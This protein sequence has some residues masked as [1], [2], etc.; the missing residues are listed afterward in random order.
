MKIAQ[1]APLWFSLPPKKFGGTELIAYNLSEKLIKRDHQ[2]TVFASGDS[3]VSGKL[4]SAWPKHLIKEKINGKVIPWNNAHFPLLNIYEAFSRANEFDI[5]HIHEN[6]KIL[7]SFFID[8]IK[9]PV[10]T[11]LHDPFPNS[12]SKD[13]LAVYN[14]FK[15]HNYI[16]ISNTH[17]KSARL[18]LNFVGTVYNG[19]D[20]E[21]YKF[22]E[23]IKKDYL[24]WLG[25]IYPT[26]GVAEVIKIAK[27]ANKKLILAGNIAKNSPASYN[28]FEQKIKPQFEKGRVEYV[29]E[30]NL[31]QKNKLL[32]NAFAFLNPIQWEEPF[33][34]VMI[35]AMACGT[36]VIAFNRGAVSEIIKDGKTGFIVKNE[37]EMV[38]AI[39]KIEQIDRK[40]CRKHIE[41][42]FSTEKMTIE[43]EKI[44]EKLI[45]KKKL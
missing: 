25:R 6:D 32:K 42:K 16:S 10:V 38:D 1:V 24:V 35:E 19:I 2:V 13:K 23:K 4:I 11:T 9:T 14:K 17:R 41:E 27:K 33:G 29:G 26:K 18:K 7:S 45:K 43:Y 12:K 8:L 15:K 44:Y 5:I 39:K 21:K 22:Q 37:K 36:P 20:L 40:D 30:V 3:N 31:S 34:L 28:Y